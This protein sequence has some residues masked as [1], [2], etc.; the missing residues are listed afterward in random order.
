MD[1]RFSPCVDTPPTPRTRRSAWPWQRFVRR[2]VEAG[3]ARH[4]DAAAT[5]EPLGPSES[6]VAREN[7][8]AP[9]VDQVVDDDEVADVVVG[10]LG[11][12][13]LIDECSVCP[14]VEVVAPLNSAPTNPRRQ[15]DQA[16][17]LGEVGVIQVIRNCDRA[18]PWSNR[19][20][21]SPNELTHV[22]QRRER[23]LRPVAMVREL[24]W[25]GHPHC[26]RSASQR[27][28]DL[29]LGR[30][31]EG[32]GPRACRPSDT[33]FQLPRRGEDPGRWLEPPWRFISARSA[34][35]HEMCGLGPKLLFSFFAPRSATSIA[36]VGIGIVC[37]GEENTG[38]DDQQGRNGAPGGGP[39]DCFRVG[40]REEWWHHQDAI[41][42]LE[43]IE[44]G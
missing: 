9:E 8:I 35:L 30:D 17:S 33:E 21:T 36:A 11:E 1:I 14:I 26:V 31:L 12:D 42:D 38:V 13:L 5:S 41:R 32:W 28:E 29:A 44:S 27:Y 22:H 20:T 43:V 4:G 16:G 15:L 7:Q 24:S 23:R 34:P 3:S 18:R 40:F 6:D 25:Q 37:C 10:A 2:V 39:F 19:R